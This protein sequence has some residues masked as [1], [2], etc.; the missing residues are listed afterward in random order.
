M[1]RR[2][3]QDLDDWASTERATFTDAE[4][5]EADERLDDW[6]FGFRSLAAFIAYPLERFKR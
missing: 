5:A 3:R 6:L 1:T 4:T 2:E